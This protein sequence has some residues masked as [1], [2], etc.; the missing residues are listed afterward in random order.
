MTSSFNILPCQ[1]ALFP[2]CLDYKFQAFLCYLYGIF[3]WENLP[4]I[5]LGPGGSSNLIHTN[6]S[7]I[8]WLDL[9]KMNTYSTLF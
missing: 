6:F 5:S 3:R 9:K 2:P 7:F 8:C 1:G 4:F